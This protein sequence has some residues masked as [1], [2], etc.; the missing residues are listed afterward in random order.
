MPQE[1][2]I[3]RVSAATFQ[4]E[5]GA[6]G[7]FTHS[8]VLNGSAFFTELEIYADGLH[9]IIGDPY[10]HATLRVRYPLND[11]YQEVR[12]SVCNQ[13]LSRV[14]LGIRMCSKSCKVGFPGWQAQ[15]DERDPLGDP[16]RGHPTGKAAWLTDR[17]FPSS[18]ACFSHYGIS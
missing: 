15:N 6:V 12:R 16:L 14:T 7:S 3:N 5:S 17:K 9:M 13:T 1:C 2:R 8:I 10:A 18:P 4:F 11:D